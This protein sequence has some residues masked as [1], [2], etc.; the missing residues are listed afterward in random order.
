MK[1]ISNGL[2]VP[3]LLI[4][5]GC[6]Q[7]HPTCDE[8]AVLRSQVGTQASSESI[9]SQMEAAGM[10]PPERIDVSKGPNGQ[11][12]R[13]Y[14]HCAAVARAEEVFECLGEPAQYLALY[15]W[16]IP[17]N[18]LS[19]DLLYPDQG[20]LAHGS[21]FYRSRPESPPP[22]DGDFPID[23]F[24][25]V[26]PGSVEQVLFYTTLGTTSEDLYEQMLQLYKAWPG[27]WEDVTVKL[28]P[29][30]EYQQSKKTDRE[31]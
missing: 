22:L 4:L 8:I 29:N 14:C 2:I 21:K 31:W 18:L 9:R 26:P 16:D 5:V 10:V 25:F 12:Q 30:L 24:I 11:V 7:G 17:G 15:E 20:I 3:L 23:V 13:L 1:R 19:L 6:A 27:K 28:G